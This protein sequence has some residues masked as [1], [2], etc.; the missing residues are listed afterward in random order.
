[1]AAALRAPDHAQLKP[2]RF[3][4]I[5]GQRREALGRLLLAAAEADNPDLPTE[6]KERIVRL[7]FRAPMIMVAICSPK[8]HPKVPHVEQMLSTG[9][10]VQQMV[11]AAQAMGLGAMW[12]TG[13]IAYDSV[14]K[15]GLGL[16]CDE[17]IVAFLYLGTPGGAVRELPRPEPSGFFC[18]W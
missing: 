2:F 15:K 17:S 5:E 1:M 3:L 8:S 11:L 12:R 18:N 7:P 10:A 14:V 6:S 13:A 16:T 4:I 9:A